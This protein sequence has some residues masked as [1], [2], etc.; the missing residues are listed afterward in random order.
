MV[1][2]VRVQGLGFG[3]VSWE[4][5]AC[6]FGGGLGSACW[7]WG[8]GCGMRVHGIHVVIEGSEFRIYMLC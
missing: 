6:H 7:I 8:F 3:A 5:G 1:L 4:L 2:G